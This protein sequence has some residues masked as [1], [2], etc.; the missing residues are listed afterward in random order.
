MAE[1]GID[2]DTKIGAKGAIDVVMNLMVSYY[3]RRLHFGVD[4]KQTKNKY[5]DTILTKSIT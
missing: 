1:E 4:L 5:Y 3:E 2:T